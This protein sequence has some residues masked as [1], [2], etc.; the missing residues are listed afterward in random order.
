[1]RRR[2]RTLARPHTVDCGAWLAK[3][4]EIALMGLERGV[5]HDFRFVATND[6]GN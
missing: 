3:Y 6:T 5:E 1:M 2:K 4:T